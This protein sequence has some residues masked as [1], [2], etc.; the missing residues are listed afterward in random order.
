MARRRETAMPDRPRIR[1]SALYV[2]TRAVRHVAAGWIGQTETMLL[3]GDIVRARFRAYDRRPFHAS[4]WD[5][6]TTWRLDEGHLPDYQ[7]R[8]NSSEAELWA[9]RGGIAYLVGSR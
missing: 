6:P 1:S 5:D 3:R 4:E 8:A 2:V 7:P 9:Q